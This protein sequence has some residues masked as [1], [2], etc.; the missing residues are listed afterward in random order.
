MLC[1]FLGLFSFDK[2]N[3]SKI[4]VYNMLIKAPI[5]LIL[6]NCHICCLGYT[7]ILQITAPLLEESM[8]D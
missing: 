2:D 3:K 4:N 5:N 1:N 7:V 6:V 8:G